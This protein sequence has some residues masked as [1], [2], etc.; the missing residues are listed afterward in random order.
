VVVLVELGRG[1]P[2]QVLRAVNV[3]RRV[4]GRESKGKNEGKGDINGNGGSNGDQGEEGDDVG[5]I[6]FV[7]QSGHRRP[8]P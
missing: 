7:C 8:P 1:V 3:G 2:R 6:P 5:A 4:K